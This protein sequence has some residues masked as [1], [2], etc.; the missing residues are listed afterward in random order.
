[1]RHWETR[2]RKL[3]P[4]LG[5]GYGYP[6][7]TLDLLSATDQN[8]HRAHRQHL[9]CLAPQQQ[10]G[11]PTTAVRRHDD[12]IAA[13]ALRCGNDALGRELVFD[14]C[15]TTSYV[16]YFCHLQCCGKD[17]RR[18]RRRSLVAFINWEGDGA[19]TTKK[20]VQGSVTVIAVTLALST[21]ASP[22][23]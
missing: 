11:Q 3:E 22:T 4:R 6:H 19:L 16:L 10:L 1:M 23:P 13:V 12:Q 9:S 18:I 5:F 20:K 8:R 7:P 2:W 14:V 21:L 17:T 15:S